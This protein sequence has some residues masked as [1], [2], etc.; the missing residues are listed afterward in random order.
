MNGFGPAPSKEL[1]EKPIA[2][3]RKTPLHKAGALIWITYRE[4]REREKSL[5]YAH[6]F[7]RFTHPKENISWLLPQQTL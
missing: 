2:T 6:P 3:M 4:K 5:V 1:E 7:L